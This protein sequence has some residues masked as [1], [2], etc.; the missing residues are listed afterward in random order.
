VALAGDLE[1]RLVTTDE[2][3]VKE[4]PRIVIHLRDYVRA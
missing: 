3:V 1:I 2:P 4:F